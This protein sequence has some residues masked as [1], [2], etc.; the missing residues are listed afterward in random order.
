MRDYRQRSVII[1]MIAM[2]MVQMPIDQIIYVV[3]MR[4]RRMSAARS[5]SMRRI[6]SATAMLWRAAHRILFSYFDHVYIDLTT[7]RIIQMA[8]VQIVDVTLMANRDVTTVGTVG[9]RMIGGGH[10]FSFRRAS[11]I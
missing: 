4:N 8:V 7:T 6:V 11:A 5:M 3:T 9:V 10:G 2:R 1:A